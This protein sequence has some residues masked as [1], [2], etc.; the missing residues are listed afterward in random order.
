MNALEGLDD[1]G[2]DAEQ[3]GPLGGPIARRARP[4]L[5]ASHHHQGHAVGLVSDG[6]VVNGQRFAAGDVAGHAALGA[7]GHFVLDADVGE[8]AAHHHLVVAAPGA[9]GVEV[10]GLDPVVHQIGA[11]RAVGHDRT[12]RR[13][14]VGGHRIAQDGEGPGA[15]DFAGASALSATGEE[16]RQTYIGG[17]VLPTNR[18][19]RRWSRWP[20]IP[21]GRSRRRRSGCGTSRATALRPG[22]PGFRRWPA[23]C[24]ASRPARRRRLRPG[25]RSTDRPTTIRPGRRPP[26]GAAEAR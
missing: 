10:P 7:G 2:A 25:G 26:P 8:S 22:P 20:A 3:K 13:D 1:D 15:Q 21:R 17:I 12:G 5:L 4:V 14:V 16:R 23:R 18:S 11:G 19:C 24:R 9:I 6:G